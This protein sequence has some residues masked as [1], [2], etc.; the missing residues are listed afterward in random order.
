LAKNDDLIE[1]LRYLPMFDSTLKDNAM[2]CGKIILHVRLPDTIRML[3][4]LAEIRFLTRKNPNN[5]HN[6]WRAIML[7]L[8]LLGSFSASV[9]AENEVRM[10]EL[11]SRPAGLLAFLALGRGNYFSRGQILQSLWGDSPASSSLGSF[12]TTLWRLRKSLD[13]P[14]VNAE[15]YIVAN[16]QGA[17]GLNGPGAFW[18]DVDEF[19]R[20]TQSSLTKPLHQVTQAN[21]R[22][23]EI[24]LTLY[25]GDVLADFRDSWALIERE[26]YR[27]AY[28]NTL[29]RLMEIGAIKRDYL[30][31]I[32]YGQAILDL[33]P[34]REDVHRELMRYFFLSGQRAMALKQFEICRHMLKQELAINPMR[35]TMSLYQRIADSAIAHQD[36]LELSLFFEL[37][38]PHK[39][40]GVPSYKTPPRGIDAGQPEILETSSCSDAA[41]SH[42][43]EIMR[44]IE[45]ADGIL[46]L[47]LRLIKEN[48]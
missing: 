25:G 34:L 12:N 35:E 18:L 22:D 2:S 28:L 42:I 39:G 36:E 23:M 11:S 8:S 13:L 7:K 47:A 32:R 44:L 10:L 30:A 20:L 1:P 33:D 21:Q 4:L 19:A 6:Y 40:T 5:H 9:V 41:E 29:G 31:S 26:R 3:G 27:R 37:D 14:P 43:T 15:D 17:I 38:H 46:Y 24:A 16:H 45:Q 48:L